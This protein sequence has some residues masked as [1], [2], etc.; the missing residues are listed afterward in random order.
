MRKFLFA[1][2]TIK[3][4]L[5]TGILAFMLPVQGLLIYSSIYAIKVTQNQVAESYRDMISLYM[6]QIDDR[7]SEADNF[8]YK[9]IGLDNNVRLMANVLDDSDYMS[10]KVSVYITLSRNILIYDIVE[11]FF[12]YSKSHNDFVQVFDS[13]VRI[14]ERTIVNDYLRNMAHGGDNANYVNSRI[15]H[16]QKLQGQ[17]YLFNVLTMNDLYVGAWT[18]VEN[19]KLDLRLITVGEKGASFFINENAEPMS[20]NAFIRDN[21]VVLTKDLYEHYFSGRNNEYLVIGES[22]QR[23]DFS[24]VAVIL[25]STILERL[26]HMQRIIFWMSIIFLILLPMYFLLLRRTIFV[27]LRGMLRVMKKIHDGDLDRRIEVFPVDEEFRIVNETFNNMMKQIKELKISIYEEKIIRQ[28]AELMYLQMQVN[29]HFFLNT[30]NIIYSLARTKKFDLIQ[31]MTLCLIKYFRYMF[32]KDSVF[33]TLEEELQHFKNYIRIQQ[34]RFSDKIRYE[35]SVSDFLLDMRIPSLLIV[36]FAENSVK[37]AVTPDNTICIN[38]V[39]DIENR[40]D[41]PYLKILIKDTGPGF[42][43]DILCK[44]RSSELISDERGDHI[45]IWN[46]QKRLKML[47]DDRAHVCLENSETGGASVEILIPWD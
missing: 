24:M 32:K 2:K 22:S 17:Y 28:N 36:M 3:F 20:H 34:I 44:L 27:P 12:I 10:A 15:W 35:I 8:L 33:V 31:E 30:L 16:T 40:Y 47:Y 11:S 21:A 45:G 1:I 42:E 7:L 39:I 23:G 5:F 19:L 46:V 18:R 6:G 14:D 41:V 37:Y 9:L 25:V 43:D 26:P 4:K 29:P 13:A 38:I